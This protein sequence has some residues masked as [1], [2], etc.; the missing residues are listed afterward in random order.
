MVLIIT[1]TCVCVSDH[2]DRGE[3]GAVKGKRSS[4]SVNPSILS[5]LNDAG[6]HPHLHFRG[7]RESFRSLDHSL[8]AFLRS[9]NLPGLEYK[10]K[11]A[12]FNS[13]KD[14]AVTDEETLCAYGF[15]PLMAQRL[16]VA[17]EDY[18]LRQLDKNEEMQLPFQL[19]RKGQKIQSSPTEKMKELPTF[20]KQNIKRPKVSDKK[21]NKS[22]KGE[23]TSKKKPTKP[24]LSIVRLMSEE[25]IPTEPIFPN[26]NILQEIE[27][28]GTEDVAAVVPGDVGVASRQVGVVSEREGGMVIMKSSE[29]LDPVAASPVPLPLS[30]ETATNVHPLNMQRKKRPTQPFQ[31]FYMPDEVDTGTGG[32]SWME[33]MGQR[34]QRSQSVPA[35]YHFFCDNDTMPVDYWCLPALVHS[36]SCPP[37]LAVPM[38]EV[39]CILAELG[40]SHN[41]GTVVRSLRQLWHLVKGGSV[42]KE[43][44]VVL[45]EVLAALCTHPVAMEIA[46]RT[47]K[48]LTRQ[49][50]NVARW[51]FMH[52]RF[53]CG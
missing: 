16:L 29:E 8:K 43:G 3:A 33:E 11:L 1:Y 42:M 4:R 19:V 50:G 13:L 44:V 14:I 27:V 28:F 6:F 30:N 9:S 46:L 34:L 22:K 26:V 40:S 18:V 12:G 48:Y 31:E 21:V 10:L 51:N 25:S 53:G 35:D 15:T 38:S 5:I 49:G 20:G 52:T 47:L 36:Y 39:E 17:L 41:V 23:S 32:V 24:P 45:L 37:S 2:I 7:T